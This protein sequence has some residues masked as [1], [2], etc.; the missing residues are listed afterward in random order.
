M[1]WS[2]RASLLP[3]TFDALLEGSLVGVLYLAL[4]LGGPGS[5]A[6]LTLIEF[7]LAA[8][9]GLLVSRWRPRRLKRISWV[10][11][12]ALLCSAAGWLADPAARNSLLALWDPQ[13]ALQIHPAGWLLGLAVLRGA[14]HQKAEVESET[15]IQ[16]I[17]IA[18]PV[19]A[20][21]LLMHVGSG[22][23]FGLS[24][25]VGSAVCVSA[26]LLAI[27]H[28]R[29]RELERLGSITRG[30]SSWPTVAVAV[31]AIAALTIPVAIFVG[32]TGRDSASSGLGSLAGAAGTLMDKAGDAANKLGSALQ[33]LLATIFGK[34]PPRPLTPIPDPTP[35]PV[36]SFHPLSGPSI[37]LSVPAGAGMLVVAALVVLAVLLVIRFLPVIPGR[38]A[39]PPA[40]ALNEER[41]RDPRR[42]RFNLHIP[43]P[44]FLPRF[45]AR[46]RPTSAAQAYVALLD[47][48]A[49]QG[50]LGRRPAETPRD[51]AGRTA[52][53]GLPH[54][55][56]GLLA[57]DYELAVY[58]QAAI[59]ER[60]N[61]RALGRWRRLRKLAKR[62]PRGKNET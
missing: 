25:F 4:A 8:G 21:A 62:L 37:T 6:P 44:A 9:G 34:L 60:E 14:A 15:A 28:A 36:P 31:V 16:A 2:W 30:G 26:G 10:R 48:L 50:E 12:L 43:R 22:D 47:D 32:T 40:S 17:T 59:T 46:R 41:R 55:P 13:A 58:G 29:L 49:D 19:L 61:K 23:A 35:M 51:H 18:F 20:L 33:Q 3:V 57:A 1:R 5:S 7:W 38:P 11:A 39:M 54:L 45:A 52:T 24:A 56:L 27:G 53:L 42:P